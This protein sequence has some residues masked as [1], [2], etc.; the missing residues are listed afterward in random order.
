[1]RGHARHGEALG[2]VLAEL[3]IASIR[4]IRISHDGLSSNFI[5]G[6]ILRRMARRGRNRDGAEDAIW[7]AR[8]PLQHLHAAHRSADDAE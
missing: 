6:D 4:P 2:R 8:H 5:E 3:E 7:I 1:M